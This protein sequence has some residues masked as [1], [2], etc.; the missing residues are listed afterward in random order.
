MKFFVKT[1]GCQMNERDSDAVTA[2]LVRRGHVRVARE[3]AADVILVNTCSVRGKAEDKAVGKLGLLTAH[4]RGERPRIVGAM[5][6]MVERLQADIFARVPGLA[7]A[8]GTHNLAAL[9]AVLDRAAAGEQR[10][11]AVGQDGEQGRDDL[12]EHADRAESAFINILY[13][14][15]RRCSYCIV[16]AVRGPEWSRAADRV[17]AEARSLALAGTREITLLGQSVMAYGLRTQ[18]WPAGHVS[19]GGYT[20]PLTRLLEALAAIEGLVRLRFTSGHPSG[21]SAELARAM[22]ELPLVCEHLHLPLQSGSDRILRSMRRGYTTDDYRAAVARLRAAV[23]SLA[24]TTDIIVGFPGEGPDDFAMTRDFAEEIGFD[25]AFI[26]KYS[27]RPGTPS[28]AWADD[29]PAE[30]KL[31]RNRIL[32]EDQDVR[33]LAINRQQLGCRVEV[34]VEGVSLRDESR[35]AGRSR[36]NK[37]VI[38]EPVAGVRPGDLVNV[39]IQDA[40]PQTLYGV[41]EDAVVPVQSVWPA[42]VDAVGPRREQGRLVEMIGASMP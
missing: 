6:C 42:G 12:S 25:N 39:R 8:V 2:L 33:G 22:A 5:G 29:V 19:P 28:A 4:R 11:L 20:E 37:I 3:D 38:F 40:R 9:P 7:F 17:V 15:N 36:T 10:I 16:P 24:L 32:L 23:P 31:R 18:V 30:E 14:C 34:L 35:W 41:V 13:G 26:F 27:P 21:C 1:Y